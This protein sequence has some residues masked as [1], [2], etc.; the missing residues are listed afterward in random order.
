MKR[1]LLVIAIAA[2]FAACNSKD[3]GPSSS[4]P[5]GTIESM[6]TAMKSGNLEDFKKFITKQDVAL[7]EEGMK[8]ISSIDSGFVKKAQ[9]TMA[10][11]L[12]EKSK[13]I[14]YKLKNEK[15]D[16]DQATVD[17]EV[18]DSTKTDSHTFNLVTEEGAWKIAL[19][20]SGYVMFNNMKGDLSKDEPD[21]QEGL[22]KLKNM[23][24]DTLKLIMD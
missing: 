19:N 9:E 14:S 4:S 20:K 3:A 5:S 21:L 13:N 16:G 23:N 11:Q 1:I 2:G 8:F 15:I 6:F 10:A 17:V 24:K 18:T 7:L 12:K 22:E